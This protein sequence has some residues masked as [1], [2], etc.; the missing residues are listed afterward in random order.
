MAVMAWFKKERKPRTS[1]RERL[2]IPAD[3]WEKCDSCGHIDIREKFEKA[4]NV[5]PECGKHQ[6]LVFANIEW[7]PG[8]PELA[9]CRCTHCS[10]LIPPHRKPWMLAHGEWRTANPK[11]KIAGFWIS[12]L[13]SP[14]KEWPDTAVEFLEAKH[15]GPETRLHQHRPR[16]IV[17]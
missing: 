2:E 15:G 1:Q 8:Q 9:K 4:L 11:S 14:W 5:C 17:G 10:V 16:G 12:Q 3:A 6:V 13:Y 7:P